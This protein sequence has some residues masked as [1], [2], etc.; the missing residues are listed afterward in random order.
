MKEDEKNWLQNVT[1]NIY[2]YI[3][4]SDFF[5]NKPTHRI[6]FGL[7]VQHALIISQVDRLSVVVVIIIGR[8]TFL[9][10]SLEKC[11]EWHR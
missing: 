8:Y 9:F 11:S 3:F 2:L 10:H 7:F 5:F 4:L 1:H 6:S